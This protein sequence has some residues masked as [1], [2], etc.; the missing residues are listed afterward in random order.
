MGIEIVVGGQGARQAR[1]RVAPVRIEF[2]DGHV[3]IKAENAPLRAILAEWARQ[4]GTRMVNAERV[5]SAPVT[6]DLTNAPERQALDILLRGVAGYMIGP[7]ETSAADAATR[8]LRAKS[9]AKK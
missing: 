3:T 2:A 7:R 1:R 4:G 8:H 5:T 9:L 6:L